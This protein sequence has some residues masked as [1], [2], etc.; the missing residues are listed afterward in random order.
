MF[1][2]VQNSGEILEE[3]IWSEENQHE[4]CMSWAK[5]GR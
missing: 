4:R 2:A 5:S 1:C 3:K